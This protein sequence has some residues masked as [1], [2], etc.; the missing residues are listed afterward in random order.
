MAT[1]CG[2]F[3]AAVPPP[4]HDRTVLLAVEGMEELWQGWYDIQDGIWRDTGA[5][6]IESHV[7]AYAEQPLA[8]DRAL[9]PTVL[10]PA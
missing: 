2:T 4:D 6:P 1:F 7:Y 8:P 3:V 5:Y 10:E 9:F